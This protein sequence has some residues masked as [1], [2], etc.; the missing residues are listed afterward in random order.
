M[1][2]VN[3]KNSKEL[4]QLLYVLDGWKTERSEG[5]YG[6]AREWERHLERAYEGLDVLISI[7]KGW[8]KEEPTQLQLDLHVAKVARHCVKSC[9]GVEGHKAG[10]FEIIKI[11]CE[12]ED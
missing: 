5:N 6:S 7:E 9:T 4:E 11:A 12:E 2:N 10:M 1:S 8:C 3:W